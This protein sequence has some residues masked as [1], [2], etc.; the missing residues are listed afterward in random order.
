[1]RNVTMALIRS[2]YANLL[3][4]SVN[5]RFSKLRGADDDRDREVDQIAPG[6]EI[7]EALHVR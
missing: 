7:P 1:M 5:V 4:C 2:P 3:P 6:K